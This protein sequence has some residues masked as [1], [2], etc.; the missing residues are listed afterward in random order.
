VNFAPHALTRR[1][2][3]ELAPERFRQL[4]LAAVAMLILIVGTGATVRLTGSG[5]GCEHWPGCQPGDP[6]PKKGYHSYIEFSNR[7]VAFFTVVTT[8]ALAV[9][10]L[11]TRGLGRRVKVLAGIVFAATLAQAPLGAITV[12]FHLNPYL[13]IAHLL[14]S[15]AVI[16][17]AVL[18]LLD[19][20]QLLRGTGGA[21]PTAVRTTGGLLLGAITFL[22]VTGTLSTAS[23]KY[24]GSSGDTKV[25]RLGAFEPA[26][27][28]HVKAVATFGVVFLLL[29]AWALRNR[30]RFP[31]LVRGCA[32]LLAILLAQMAVGETQYRTYLTVPWWLVLIH[33]ILAAALFAWT[34]GLVARLWRPVTR[35]VP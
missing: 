3:L 8:L 14:L 20:T 16:G 6:F 34:V 30:M 23:G 22:V 9:G 26:V 29:A 27:S 21:L 12:Y 10:A 28:L 18:V 25:R 1:W 7:V 17:V 2:A 13:V 35:N 33:V 4:A 11:R 32:G 15:L 31:W 24:P 19:A 5:L